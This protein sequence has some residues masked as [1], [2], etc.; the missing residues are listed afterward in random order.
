MA[1]IFKQKLGSYSHTETWLLNA[2]RNLA[3]T[4]KQR[5]RY[6]METETRLHSNKNL[7][8]TRKR[9]PVYHMEI[10]A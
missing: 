4:L 2:N 7:A 10:E 1:T 9:K 8:I 3:A 6:Y 5:S